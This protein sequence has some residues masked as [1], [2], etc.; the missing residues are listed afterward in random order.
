M[1]GRIDWSKVH[2]FWGDERCVPP[3]S[4]ESN[5]RLVNESLLKQIAIPGGNVHRIR[6]ERPPADAAHEYEGEIRGALALEGDQLPRF[7]IVLLGLGTDGHTASLFPA[8]AGLTERGRLVTEV[9]VPQYEAWRIT[10]TLPVI[11]NAGHILFLVS[12]EGKAEILR[13]VIGEESS[14][15][16]AQQVA[17]RS[18]LVEWYVDMD[19]ASLLT[20]GIPQ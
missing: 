4:P 16:P 11:N 12:G 9:F 6:A 17:P 5:F 14:E 2:L 8:T 7:A 19:A 13:K 10:M 20:K 1:G 15:L 18:G 3:S